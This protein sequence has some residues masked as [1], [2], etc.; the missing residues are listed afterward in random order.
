MT[1]PF[2][3]TEGLYSSIDFHTLNKELL[4]VGREVSVPAGMIIKPK[5]D[6]ILCLT[7]GQMAASINQSLEPLIGHTFPYIPIGLLERY[8]SLEIFY[9]AEVDTSFIQLTWSEFDSFYFRTP[10]HSEILIKILSFMSASLIHIYYERNNESGYATIRQML[11]R[12]LYKNEDGTLN[13]EGVASFI[14]KRTHLSRSYVFQ[15]LS[16][17]KSGGYITV[18]N[19]K[20]IAINREIPKRF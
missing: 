9:Q 3:Q 11:Y 6:E 10:Q 1:N 8:Y 18:K 16:G 19:G 15:I 2:E 7:K 20:L 12:Y 17:L 5:D 14:L 4:T 13:N